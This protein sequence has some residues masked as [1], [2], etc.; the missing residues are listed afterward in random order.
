MYQSEAPTWTLLRWAGIWSVMIRDSSPT[1]PVLM[2]LSHH[3]TFSPGVGCT[4][5]P[6]H[7]SVETDLVGSLSVISA[8]AVSV[9]FGCPSA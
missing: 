5:F 9:S 7:F 3:H 8:S 4:E 1:L 2:A 6:V